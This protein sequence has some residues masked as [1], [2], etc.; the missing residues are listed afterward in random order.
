[1]GNGWW[2][3]VNT[4]LFLSASLFL[5]LPYLHLFSSS[6]PYHLSPASSHMPS[7]SSSILILSSPRLFVLTARLLFSAPA[8]LLLP[9]LLLCYLPSHKTILNFQGKEGRGKAG[10]GGGRAAGRA[11]DGGWSWRQGW[12]LVKGGWAGAGGGGGEAPA[13]LFSAACLTCL[14]LSHSHPHSLSF[15]LTL[16]HLSLLSLSFSPPLLLSCL[17]TLCDNE[18]LTAFIHCIK[19]ASVGMWLEGPDLQSCGADIYVMYIIW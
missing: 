11:G 19:L 6:I 18:R 10:D 1:M 16:H 13:S 15:S 4:L 7:S 12:G 17:M 14:T 8:L 9:L 5:P 2:L 3:V